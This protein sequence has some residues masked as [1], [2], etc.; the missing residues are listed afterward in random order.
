MGIGEITGDAKGSKTTHEWLKSG[1]VLC[2]LANKIKPGSIA[3]VNP[4]GTGAMGDSK[5]RENINFFQK[6]MRE[7]GVPES[8]MFGT[9]DLYAE[10]DM[11]TFLI[12]M[13][14]FAGAVQTQCKDFKGPTLGPAMTHSM[15]D[16]KRSG[17]TATSQYEAMQRAMQ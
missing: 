8:S 10:K 6:M 3:K 5:A 15:D 16:V 7:T 13:S 12:S 9:D 4:P 11:G 14:A 1:Q 2:A 17:L